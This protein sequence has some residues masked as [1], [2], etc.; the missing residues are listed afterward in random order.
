MTGGQPVDGTMKVPEMTRE[1]DAEGAAKVVVVTDEPEKYEEHE[2]AAR[3]A[4]SVTVHHRDELDDIQKQLREIP[5]CTV[6]I[7]DQTCATEKR[8]RRKRGTMADPAKRV[9]INELVCEGCGDCSVQIELPVGRAGRDR[10]RQEAP[11]QP[12]HLQQGLLVPEGLL[13]ELHHRRGRPAEEREEGRDRAAAPG[14]GARRRPSRRCRSPK[15]RGASS[16]PASAAPASSPSASCSAWP[17]TS[18]A[19][20]SSRRTR[21][22]WRKRAARPGA[23]SR[24]PTGPTRSSRPRSAPPRPTW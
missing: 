17:R 20:A 24:S 5:G 12:E 14:R 16:S 7:Y 10:V 2:I 22:G 6:I 18:K 19:R 21:P 3:L 1:L 4:P 8:R 15:S 9:V 13:P 23:T 11:H